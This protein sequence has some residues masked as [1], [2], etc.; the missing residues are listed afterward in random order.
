[1]LF[2]LH[3]KI[4]N[5]KL[6]INIKKEREMYLDSFYITTEDILTATE[7][8]RHAQKADQV[9]KKMIESQIY[10]KMGTTPSA[11]HATY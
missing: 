4:E 3:R 9:Y 7:R 1:M 2:F 5:Y 10:S 8:L 11:A 6:L